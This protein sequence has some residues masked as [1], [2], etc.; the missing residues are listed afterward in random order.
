MDGPVVK[1]ARRALETGNVNL[2]LPWVQRESEE[3]LK[4][5][6]ERSLGARKGAASIESSE[7]TDLWFFETAVRLHRKGEGA[8]YTGIKPAGTLE[9]PAVPMAD[10]AI[11][12]GN[13]DKVIDFLAGA[14]KEELRKRF[15]R[16]VSKKDF[17]ENDVDAAR[18]YVQTMLGFVL[19]AGH[20]HEYI[21]S[22]GSRNEGHARHGAPAAEGA[23]GAAAGPIKA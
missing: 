14:V 7:L 5:A 17:D 23:A 21:E 20:L 1:A 15:E 22:R 3:E 13:P 2:I 19:F 9:S 18:E 4:Q 16:A 6:F 10:E 8:P 11:A 12:T